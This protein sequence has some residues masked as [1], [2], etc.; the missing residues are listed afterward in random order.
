MRMS[1]RVVGRAESLDMR[2]EVRRG[3]PQQPLGDRSQRCRGKLH[4]AEGKNRQAKLNGEDPHVPQLYP[5]RRA[6]FR[7]R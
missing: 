5:L 4:R 3:T 2:V 7:Q 1:L 6:A